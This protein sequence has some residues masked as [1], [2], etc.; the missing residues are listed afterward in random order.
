MR[1]MQHMDNRVPPWDRSSISL[2]EGLPVAHMEAI[3]HKLAHPRPHRSNGHL[4]SRPLP[5]PRTQAARIQATRWLPRVVIL[6]LP[7]RQ[8]GH[9]AFQGPHLQ[10][11]QVL[12]L[13]QLHTPLQPLLLLAMRSTAKATHKAMAWLMAMGQVE[14]THKE[15]LI[16]VPTRKGGTAAPLRYPAGYPGYGHYRAPQPAG[17]QAAAYGAYEQQGYPPGAYSQAQ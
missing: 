1:S 4:L 6:Q 9:L 11:Q 2:V 5:A 14:V 16:S 10:E 12:L 13:L 8:L 15:V 3:H 7:T 17:Q